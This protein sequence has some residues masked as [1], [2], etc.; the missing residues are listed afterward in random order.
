MTFTEAES[1]LLSALLFGPCDPDRFRE[2]GDYP[3]LW[4]ERC[5]VDDLDAFVEKFEHLAV[6]NEDTSL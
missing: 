5:G 2:G 6:A 3:A 4:A 1:R